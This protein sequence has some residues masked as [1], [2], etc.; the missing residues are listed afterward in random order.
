MVSVSSDPGAVNKP[1]LE[2]VPVPLNTFHVGETIVA[3]VY[4]VNCAVEFSEIL[5]DP[6]YTV[7][8]PTTGGFVP[9]PPLPELHAESSRI[10]MIL[11][12][13]IAVS[14]NF[15]RIANFLIVSPQSLYLL[16]FLP[17]KVSGG[18][19]IPN[20]K[21][22]PGVRFLPGRTGFPSVLTKW[23][24]VR[25]LPATCFAQFRSGLPVFRVC[26]TRS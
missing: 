13:R 20:L 7:I 15:L 18:C 16:P 10:A 6:G 26:A 9:P 1:P 11:A 24:V 21:S 4:A 17:Q 14:P 5:A 12:V 25:F 19:R 3:P 22:C 8:P 23:E 2:I